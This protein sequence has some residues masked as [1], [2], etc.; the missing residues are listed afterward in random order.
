MYRVLIGSAVALFLVACANTAPPPVMSTRVAADSAARDSAAHQAHVNYVRVINSNDIDSL[1]SMFTDDVVFLAANDKPIVGKAAVRAW[2][3]GYYKAFHTKWDK[4]QREFVVSG[5]Y[6]FE[7][8]DYTSTDTPK[9]GG[10][11]IVDTGWGF[12][13]YH[14]DADGTWRVARDAF[15]PDHPPTAKQ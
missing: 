4:P 1:A 10:K 15:G 8:Y 6:A 7:R 13:V 9:A 12:V 3:D 14:H 11:P 2:A 5:D